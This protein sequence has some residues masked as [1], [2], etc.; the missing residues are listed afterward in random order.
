MSIT[1][2]AKAISENAKQKTIGIRP[3]EKI[4]EQ[5]IGLEDAPHTYEY[6]NHYKILP[7]IY[8][9]SSDP[10]RNKNGVKVDAKFTYTSN[11][12]SEWMTIDDLR[13][14]IRANTSKIGKI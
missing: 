13:K 9:W 2:I 4:H 7:A 10:K 8:N 5:M 6:E 12:N 1:D 14:W 3:G 11:N